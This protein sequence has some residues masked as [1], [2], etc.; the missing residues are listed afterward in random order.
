MSINTQID[1]KKNVVNPY[2]EILLGTCKTMDDHQ[3]KFAK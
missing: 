3:C 1:K 2:A